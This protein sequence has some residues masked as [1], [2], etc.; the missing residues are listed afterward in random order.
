MD[1]PIVVLDPDNVLTIEVGSRC[2]VL[3]PATGELVECSVHS[4]EIFHGRIHFTT[5]ASKVEEF[6]RDDNAVDED[7]YMEYIQHLRPLSTDGAPAVAVHTREA[8]S[9]MLAT[10]EYAIC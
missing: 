6:N 2:N 7:N 5:T 4:L 9:R 1:D 8:F 3:N 10:K